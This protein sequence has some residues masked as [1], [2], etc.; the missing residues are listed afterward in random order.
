MDFK[1][2]AFNMLLNTSWGKEEI[3]NMIQNKLDERTNGMIKIE[4]NQLAENKIRLVFWRDSLCVTDKDLIIDTDCY[5]ISGVPVSA[6][7]IGEEEQPL[8]Y[9]LRRIEKNHYC[10]HKTAFIRFYR[11]LMEIFGQQSTKE[12]KTRIYTDRVILEITY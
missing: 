6:F 1:F 12:I 10:T 7:R 2:I 11:T 4:Y 5:I 9:P 8:I 3:E